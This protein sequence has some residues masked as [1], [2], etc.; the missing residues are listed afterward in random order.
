MHTH[1]HTYIHTHIHTYTHTY[2]HTYV[3]N[4]MPNIHIYRATN[5]QEDP[6]IH[7][8]INTDTDADP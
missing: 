1:I 2:I 5:I 3:H 8:D 6:Y 7:T 4:R